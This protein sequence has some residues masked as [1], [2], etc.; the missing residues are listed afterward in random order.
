MHQAV[1]L[2]PHVPTRLHAVLIANFSVGPIN[3]RRGE[4]HVTDS[5]ISIFMRRTPR[6]AQRDQQR[7]LPCGDCGPCRFA[8]RQ[9]SHV[10]HHVHDAS[11][12]N[13]AVVPIAI[14][15]SRNGLRISAKRSL[16]LASFVFI[17]GEKNNVGGIG[18]GQSSK[19]A[20]IVA[21]LRRRNESISHGTTSTIALLVKYNSD[22]STLR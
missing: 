15:C 14:R 20:A 12:A 10:A 21:A 4:E 11:P 1:R 7:R 16:R 9:I 18:H 8:R 13:L 3:Q 5:A 6:D 22:W 17:H 2:R 19:S